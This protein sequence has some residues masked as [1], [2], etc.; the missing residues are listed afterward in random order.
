MSRQRLAITAAAYGFTVAFLALW[1]GHA[2]SSRHRLISCPRPAPYGIGN[3][4]TRASANCNV[5]L[6]F[7]A[8]IALA[9]LG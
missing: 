3:L 4:I 6:V 9:I 8:L 2:A 1:E 7:A 5:P